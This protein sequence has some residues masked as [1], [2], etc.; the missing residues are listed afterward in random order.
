[1]LK[2]A[3]EAALRTYQAV[4]EQNQTARPE[5]QIDP[6]EATQQMFNA[7]LD[8]NLAV[9]GQYL[10]GDQIVSLQDLASESLMAM[11]K[12]GRTPEQVVN[13]LREQGV[14]GNL[15]QL[16]AFLYGERDQPR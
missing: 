9:T 4:S 11:K 12:S 1:M 2:S 16:L 13:Y 3:N 15:E 6:L 10:L 14:R 5:Q 7:T 8:N